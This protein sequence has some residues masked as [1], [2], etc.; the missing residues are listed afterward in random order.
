MER[1]PIMET[2]G[3][4]SFVLDYF[5]ANNAKTL[6]SKKHITI[7]LP[8]RLSEKLNCDA[9]L[10][11]TFDKEY[12]EK[13]RDIDFVAIGS[14]LLNK[15]SD[16]CEKRGLTITKIY[17]GQ[18]FLGVELNFKVTFESIDKKE[19]LYT[20]L[21]D[22]QDKKIRNDILKQVQESVYEESAD[23][24]AE[25]A[26]INECY[27][28]CINEVKSAIESEILKIK[29]K[30]KTALENERNI[31]EKFYDGLIAD[32][33]KKQEERIKS[34]KEKKELAYSSRYTEIREKYRG[35]A[36]KY[37]DKILQENERI[38]EEL[39]NYFETKEKRLQEI[40][41]QYKLQT[42]ISLYSAALI[43]MK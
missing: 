28:M 40:D 43:V 16:S 9:I 11:I 24:K 25:P 20:F 12:A 15:I 10:N 13:N 36:S 32:A 29:E 17:K 31:I 39:R 14:S 42:K 8:K 37:E 2:D 35:E 38:H 1:S 30:L 21:V 23:I 41:T 6:E 18:A 27:D 34:W 26:A 7:Q 4:K 19:K 5:K 33:R 3:I 22:L